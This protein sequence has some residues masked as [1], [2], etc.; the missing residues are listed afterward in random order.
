M[1]KKDQVSDLLEFKKFIQLG[2]ASQFV[3]LVQKHVEE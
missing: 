2:F 3:D 1:F